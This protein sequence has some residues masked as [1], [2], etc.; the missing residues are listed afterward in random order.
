MKNQRFPALPIMLL[1]AAAALFIAQAQAVWA[2]QPQAGAAAEAAAAETA[3]GEADAASSDGDPGEAPE[4]EPAPIPFDPAH[5][6]TLRQ[7]GAPYPLNLRGVDGSDS[8]PFNVRSDQ[9]VTRA[10]IDLTY[11][12][13]PALLSDLSHINVLLNDEVAYSIPVPREEGGKS[14]QRSIELPPYLIT[15]FN[16]LRFQLIGHYTL[17]CEDP[18]HSS[19][20]ANLSNESKLRLAIEP[21]ALPDDLSLLPLPFFDHRD[22]RRLSLP[23][24]FAGDKGP[25]ALEAAGMIA[26]WFGALAD[27]RAAEFPV[28]WDGALPE[29][30]S[31]IVLGVGAP[32]HGASGLSA[33][34]GPTLAVTPNPNDSHGK[35][36]WVLGRDAKELK[37]AAQ[38]LVTGNTAL[39]GPVATIHQLDEVEPR[40]PYDAPR[41][42][43]GDRPV[44]FGEIV[45]AASL[46]VRGYNAA[47]IR[48]PVR[49]APDLFGWREKPVQVD[50]RYRYTP[51]PGQANSSMIF[52]T[53]GQ[54][55]RTF[56]LLS[57][58]QLADGESVLQSLDDDEMLPIR[59]GVQ[60]PLHRLLASADL[61]FQFM[62]DYIK[63]GQCRDIIIDNV[64]GHVD[65][66]STIDLS[67]FPH[68]MQMPNLAAFGES[69]FPYTRMAD[70][71]E[72]AVVMARQPAPQDVETYLALMGSFGRATGYPALR[73]TVGQEAAGLQSAADKDLIIIA[74]DRF[75]WLKDWSRHMPATVSGEKK[76]FTTS[77]LIFRPDLW[78]LGDPNAPVQRVRSDLSY[79]SQGGTALFAG[80]E[81]PLAQGR[82]VVLIAGS[83]AADQSL[84]VSA[85][86]KR[87]GFDKGLQGSLDVV[88][89]GGIHPL[90]AE[91]TY[92]VGRLGLWRG[93]QWTIAQHW[94]ALW[95]LWWLGWLVL[96]A[97]GLLLLAAIV[98]VWRR[99]RRAG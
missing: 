58:A 92:T 72:T 44:K 75:E 21:L 20:W 11:A 7:L 85:L 87:Q 86:L 4:P 99:V 25:A 74:S 91:H 40:K 96:I 18:L 56:P 80:F 38:A 53:D 77:D 42:L 78:R 90:V 94:P 36:L 46:D 89:D 61:E 70:L 14:L 19:L 2:Q 69:G 35:L 3:P 12:Y 50:L 63:E 93:F 49:V 8:V 32:A 97:I 34:G 15:D 51:Q 52:S 33:L 1:L 9:V 67:H 16:R 45:P 60:V 98:H 82:S 39:S 5:E 54:F 88:H 41:W 81:S 68:F 73:V 30:G 64:R 22:S 62:Y 23:F 29:Q 6:Y 43:P 13:S 66:D 10:A 26:S 55:L 28:R 76:R 65:P 71:S 48:L 59:A 84:A 37:L 47:P 83:T 24:V 57:V 27:Y 17:D 31:A 95:H 79:S